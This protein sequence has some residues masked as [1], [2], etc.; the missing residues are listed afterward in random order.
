MSKLWYAGAAVEWEEA[1]P[2]GNGRLGAMVY[3]GTE[4]EHIQLSEESIWYGGPVNRVNPD[5]KEKLPKIR[6]LIFEG[7]IAEAEKLMWLAQSG[8]PNSMHP[9]QTLG[10]I[11]IG[12]EGMKEVTDYRRELD[13][14]NALARTEFVKD[15]VAYERTYFTSK[16]A[17]LLVMRFAASQPGMLSFWAGMDRWKFF[18]G[19]RKTEEDE[20]YLYGNLG[21]GGYEFGMKLKALHKG[22][23]VSVIG[24]RIVVEA[25]DEVILLFGADTTYHHSKE[26]KETAYTEYESFGLERVQGLFDVEEISSWER[27]ELVMQSCLQKMLEKAIDERVRQAVEQG[28]DELFAVHEADYRKLFDA[29]EFTLEDTQKYDEIPTDERIRLAG[30]GKA[31]IGLSKIFFDFGRYLLIS[32]SR[33][34]D[35]AANLQGIWNKD[36]TPPWDCKFTININTE[37]NYWLAENCNL[38]SCHMPMFDLI[39]KMVKSGRRV[40]REMYGCRGFVCHHNTDI[41]GDCVTQDLWI[42]GSYWVMGAAWM[43]TH[44]W[45]HYQF[46]KD[47]AFL[48][49]QFPIMCEAALFFLDFLVEK[50]GYLVTCPSVSPEN[51]FILPN[52]EKGA[53]S[54]GVTMDNQILRDLFGQC[55]L[56]LKEL[57]EAKALDSGVMEALKEAEITDIHEFIRQVEDAMKRLKETQIGS[58][59]RILEWQEEFEEWEP[60]HRHVSHLYGMHPSEQITMDET[61]ELARAARK[62]LE[63]RL[64]HGGGH[65]GWSRAWI[66]NHYA[67]LWDGETAYHHLEQ[68]F[69][70]S[71]YPNMFDKHPPFQ[72]DGNFGATAGIGEMLVQSSDKRIVLL[73]AL[74]S[75][76]EKGSIRGLR[77]KGNAGVA[78]SWEHGKVKE[79]VIT[80]DSSLHTYVKYGNTKKEISLSAGESITFTEMDF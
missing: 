7:K 60:G 56:S 64:S 62:T 29:C 15:G 5:M 67:K 3:G 70:C 22:G 10:D 21:R 57:E 68:L 31:D 48:Q 13:L 30:E 59:G 1:L 39:E 66:I 16:P 20:I 18:D 65:T 37:M 14:S 9:T 78:L 24:E 2:L 42:P 58:D 28:Y 46:T 69:A 4:Y 36:M 71:T 6:R 19:V 76:W 38:S 52:G 23:K 79:C 25:A 49:K 73:P 80:A 77:V 44:Q 51:T 40:A 12:F 74:P 54:Y 41:H 8:C 34:G 55:I 43:C 17:Q 45:T 47:I 11:T 35:L 61:P 33:E 27:K 50:D 26:E 32:C 72:I 53:N 63:Y 75:V